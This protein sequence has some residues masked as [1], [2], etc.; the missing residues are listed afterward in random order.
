MNV[1]ELV[2]L[3]ER[4]FDMEKKFVVPGD[5]MGTEE[6]YLPGSGTVAENEK[7]YAVVA[8]ETKDEERK[9]SITQ[10]N[11]LSAYGIGS[12]IIGRVENIVEPIALVSIQFGEGQGKRFGET[13]DYSVLH[14]SMIRKGYVKNV[15]DEY[16]VG[17]IIRA[18]IV[19]LR[20][21]EFRLSTDADELGAIKA[22]CGKCRKPMKYESG[23]VSC[24]ECGNKDNRKIAK[25]YRKADV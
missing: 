23:V 20:N 10:K 25:D 1:S 24:E 7:I 15:R 11:G 3:L 9:L 2:F 6:E 14:A 19:D 4:C 13:G 12:V 18:K 17:D 8:G 22:F 16:K 21:G 5:F